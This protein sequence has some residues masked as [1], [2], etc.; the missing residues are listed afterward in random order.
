MKRHAKLLTGLLLAASWTLAMGID[1]ETDKG[2]SIFDDMYSGFV[3]PILL[4]LMVTFITLVIYLRWQ[5]A[6]NDM[7][8]GNTIVKDAISKAFKKAWDAIKGAWHVVG[9][10][11]KRLFPLADGGTAAQVRKMQTAVQ[12]KTAKEAKKAPAR[13]MQLTVVEKTGEETK[14]PVENK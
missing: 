12:K 13:K 4:G 8:M 10:G 7:V 5:G 1:N 6:F 11:V 2:N 14:K 3:L 9:D